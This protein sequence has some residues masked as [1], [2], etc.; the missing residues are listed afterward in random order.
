MQILSFTFAQLN[1]KCILEQSIFISQIAINVESLN[2]R[3]NVHVFVIILIWIGG[4]LN[5]FQ[6]AFILLVKMSGFW[7]R[8]TQSVYI[9]L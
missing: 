9:S 5:L 3:T 1:V 7:A 8:T 6:I 2:I 4:K